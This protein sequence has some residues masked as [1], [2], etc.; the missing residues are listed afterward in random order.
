[1]LPRGKV[2]ARCRS[3]IRHRDRLSQFWGWNKVVPVCG[4]LNLP[5]SYSTGIPWSK[6]NRSKGSI[7]LIGSLIGS[8]LLLLLFKSRQMG[9]LYRTKSFCKKSC[10]WQLPQFLLPGKDIGM[11]RMSHPEWVKLCVELNYVPNQNTKIPS[12]TT[13]WNK[14]WARLKLYWP[15]CYRCNEAPTDIFKRKKRY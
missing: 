9:R 10:V 11:I 1:M 3:G 7:N 15:R 6:R 13:W 14:V 12:A 4:V 5:N 8:M 2:V